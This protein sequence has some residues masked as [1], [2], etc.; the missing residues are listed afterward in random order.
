MSTN[1]AERN[2]QAVRAIHAA[3][4]GDDPASAFEIMQEVFD[5]DVV[6]YEPDSLPYGGVYRGLN[7]LLGML[8]T[9]MGVH[10]DTPRIKLEDIVAEG[11]NVVTR[12]R[13]PFRMS[14]NEPYVDV[15]VSEWMT[16]RDGKIIEVRPFYWD[17]AQL[18][19]P[20]ADTK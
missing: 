20:R 8:G 5:P 13:Y 3:I 2:R 15:E 9:A 19:K 7:D 11:D 17:T 10:F 1:V 16:F 12:W 4:T 14:A 18:L 6:A